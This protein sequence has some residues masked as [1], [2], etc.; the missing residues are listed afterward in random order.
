MYT[1]V[2]ECCACECRINVSLPSCFPCVL[3]IIISTFVSTSPPPVQNP[4][5]RR[6]FFSFHR[7]NFCEPWVR[8]GHPKALSAS[9]E[10]STTPSGSRRVTIS[11][12]VRLLALPHHSFAHHRSLRVHLRWGSIWLRSR[13]TAIPLDRWQVQGRIV[14]RGMVLVS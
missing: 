10:R 7:V 11:S 1:R 6:P 3:M 9:L 14:T 5:I 4:P 12:F 8:R 13:S 2:G